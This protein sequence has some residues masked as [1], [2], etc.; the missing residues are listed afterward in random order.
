MIRKNYIGTEAASK[1]EKILT[2]DLYFVRPKTGKDEKKDRFPCA[3]GKDAAGSTCIVLLHNL[4]KR[5]RRP[6][7]SLEDM[8]IHNKN[9]IKEAWVRTGSAAGTNP[10]GLCESK[11]R[12]IRR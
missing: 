11:M 6:A 1:V 8:S 10:L 2:P 7:L 4:Y 3:L 5:I 9:R 12:H